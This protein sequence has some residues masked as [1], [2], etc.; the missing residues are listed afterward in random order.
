MHSVRE[1]LGRSR[2]GMVNRRRAGLAA[3]TLAMAM[4]TVTPAGA[5]S[6]KLAEPS[7]RGDGTLGPAAEQAISHG[8]LPF[9]KA[10]VAAKA[11]ANR[12]T[13]KSEAGGD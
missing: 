7:E 13:A 6:L 2:R 10:D 1:F 5:E 9:S 3:M 4:A 12:A 8:P 11:E